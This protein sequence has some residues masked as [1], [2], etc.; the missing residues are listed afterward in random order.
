MNRFVKV[1]LI[2][3]TVV[4]GWTAAM[5]VLKFVRLYFGW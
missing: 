5:M 4:L 3:V 1:T 2:L